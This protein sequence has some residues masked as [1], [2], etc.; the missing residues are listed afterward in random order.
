[1][2]EVRRERRVFW[3]QRGVVREIL[4]REKMWIE[5]LW[6]SHQSQNQV[7][8]IVLDSMQLNCI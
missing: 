5:K 8:L 2:I 3:K 7:D 4:K 1:M 6:F